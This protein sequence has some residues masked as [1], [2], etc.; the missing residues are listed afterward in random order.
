[1]SGRNS[2]TGGSGWGCLGC[3][4]VDPELPTR[5]FSASITNFTASSSAFISVSLVSCSSLSCSVRFSNCCC[6]ALICSLIRLARTC[7][8]P[9]MSRM[10]KPPLIAQ[11]LTHGGWAI[12]VVTAQLG[13][14]WNT[15]RAC[16]RFRRR[17]P[18]FRWLWRWTAPRRRS[19]RNVRELQERA[20]FSFWL[21]GLR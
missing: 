9:R 12:E 13:E 4:I 2:V 16:S 15:F 10:G 7:R 18:L 17:R 8:S 11:I 21:A 20:N 3:G 19:M 14:C 1:M 6:A 5:L